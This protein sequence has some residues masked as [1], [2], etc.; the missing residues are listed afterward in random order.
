M[1]LNIFVSNLCFIYCRGCYSYSREENCKKLL[2]T[3]KIIDFMKYAYTRG[4]RKV[5]LCGGDPLTRPD[6][7]TLLEKIKSLG[8]YISL[9][10]VGTSIIRDVIVNGKTKVK[11]IDAYKLAKLVD[12]VG[13]PI[14]GTTNEIIG[15]FRPTKSDIINEQISICNELYKAGAKICINTVVHKGNL[16]NSFELANL[17]K[18]LKGV[19]KWQMFQFA[20]LGKFGFMNRSLFEIKKFQF[21]KFKSDVKKIFNNSDCQLEFKSSENRIKRYMLIDD[22]GNAWVPSFENLSI[23]NCSV[24]EK[25]NRVIIGNI[26]NCDD[27]NKICSYLINDFSS[28]KGVFH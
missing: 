16:N 21:D 12:M 8:F 10:T 4:I 5:T 24:K 27:W 1:H 18:N 22:S 14:D 9:D 11:K 25:N 23:D 28:K 13:I 17:I 26:L 15:L 20:P 19:K 7:I 3:D 2:P 6:I